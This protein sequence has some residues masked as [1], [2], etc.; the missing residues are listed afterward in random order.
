MTE[1]VQTPLAS[2]TSDSA[3]EQD[4]HDDPDSYLLDMPG[5]AS[6][7]SPNKRLLRTPKCARCR[8]H[9]VISCLKGHKRYCRWR[10]CSCPNCLLVVERQRVMAAQVALRRHQ[11]TEINKT[12][13]AKVKN[14]AAL[15]QQRKLLHR[16]LRSLQQHSLSKEILETYRNRLHI[17][18]PPEALRSIMPLMNERMR[19]RRCFADK[20]LEVAMFARERQ[21]ELDK[22]R[23]VGAFHTHPSVAGFTSSSGTSTD[24][25]YANQ[26]A[27][28]SPREL[29]QRIFPYHNANVLELVLQGCGGNIEKAI[30]QIATGIS[31]VGQIPQQD[32]KNQKKTPQT[33]VQPVSFWNFYNFSQTIVAPPVLNE[34][35]SCGQRGQYDPPVDLSM[36]APIPNK[37]V[38][39]LIPKGSKGNRS[40]AFSAPN[41]NGNLVTNGYEQ[42]DSKQAKS[43]I[44][45][46]VESIIAK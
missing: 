14:A 31:S 34:S 5:K 8:N 29:L 10:D 16:N 4:H 33:L 32:L 26:M 46:S 6:T 36:A 12:L 44:K 11:T 37:G 28:L 21:L 17:L 13:K 39:N 40:S 45:F 22:Y 27:N 18:P 41:K 24:Q 38:V 43:L 3:S 25:E 35:G 7:S 30:E 9:G 23:S 15:L 20:D 1:E 42:R 19:K 2:S